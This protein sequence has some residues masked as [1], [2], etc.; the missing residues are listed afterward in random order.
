[1]T[2]YGLLKINGQDSRWERLKATTLTGAKR[3][4]RKHAVEMGSLSKIAC[5]AALPDNCPHDNYC[6]EVY[7]VATLSG[8]GYD[9]AG[10]GNWVNC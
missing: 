7:T 4:M 10:D 3:I 8:N 2:Y 1:M 9:W 6:L 5:I